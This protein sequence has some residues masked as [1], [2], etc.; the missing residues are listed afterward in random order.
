MRA[1]G[2]PLLFYYKAIYFL[3]IIGG[4]GGGAGVK[5]T[6]AHACDT[7]TAYCGCIPIKNAR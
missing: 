2:S 7:I 1:A 6:R 5:L 4:A 3:T